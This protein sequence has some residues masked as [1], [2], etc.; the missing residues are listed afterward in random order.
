MLTLNLFFI[1]L[2]F[3]QIQHILI[4]RFYSFRYFVGVS[5]KKKKNCTTPDTLEAFVRLSSISKLNIEQLF[6]FFS[7]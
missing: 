3:F 7:L 1:I 4:L 6:L 2:F 5:P